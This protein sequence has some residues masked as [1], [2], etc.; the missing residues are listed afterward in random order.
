VKRLPAQPARTTLRF[1]IAEPLTFPVVI[2]KGTRA[3]PDGKLHFATVDEARIEPGA[4]SVEVKAE[5]LTPGT[6]G[7][8]FLPGQINRLVDPVAY[9]VRVENTTVSLGGADIES[10]D[11]F[12]ERIRLAPESFS[13]AG[14]RGAY[15]FWAR[16]AH[17]DIAD[18]SVWSPAPGEVRV[19]VLM[20]DGELP[21]EEILSRVAEVLSSEKVRPLT[22]R[23]AVQA[24]EVVTYDLALTYWVHREYEALVSQ[25]QQAVTEAVNAYIQWQKTKLGRDITPSVLVDYVQSVEGVK[26]VSVASPVYQ[27]VDPWQV[28]REETVTVTYGGLEDA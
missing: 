20:K 18:V 11:H 15:E 17:Q 16:S 7:N 14:S 22:D 21:S 5:C 12:R 19:C 28:A 8:G 6:V 10:D 27:K 25:I 3:T 2:P 24:P 26:R 4:T 1:E 13:N 9:V 23:V